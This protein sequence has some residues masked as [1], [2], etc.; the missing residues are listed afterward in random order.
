MEPK[1]RTHVIS[2]RPGSIY[3]VFEITF[4][5]FFGLGTFL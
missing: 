1:K 2:N 5:L 3:S 4:I